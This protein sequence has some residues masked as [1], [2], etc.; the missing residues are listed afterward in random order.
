MILRYSHVVTFDSVASHE[1]LVGFEGVVSD[2]AI[3]PSRKHRVTL[4][5]WSELPSTIARSHCMLARGDIAILY[6]VHFFQPAIQVTP[7]NQVGSRQNRPQ[8]VG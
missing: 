1:S 5:Y 3:V 2:H 6:A 8:L 7:S 4:H